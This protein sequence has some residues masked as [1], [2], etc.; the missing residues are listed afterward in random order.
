MNSQG[1]FAAGAIGSFI[2]PG[3]E[4]AWREALKI[5]A[6]ETAKYLWKQTHPL[7]VSASLCPLFPQKRTL[8]G[9][10]RIGHHA[11]SVTIFCIVHN[12]LAPQS[13]FYAA[14]IPSAAGATA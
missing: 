10:A 9:A 1:R 13:K 11:E 8:E 5:N 2:K 6:L 12:K 7:S 3:N 4:V 14:F